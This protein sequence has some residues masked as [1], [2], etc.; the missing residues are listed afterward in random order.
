CAARLPSVQTRALFARAPCDLHSVQN[1]SFHYS[2]Q[3]GAK[4]DRTSYEVQTSKS[5]LC[6]PLRIS[7]ALCVEIAVVRRGRRDTQRAAEENPFCYTSLHA[8]EKSSRRRY[9]RR[10]SADE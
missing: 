1:R 4:N 6:G 2:F 3:L 10:F 5:K 9:Y 8:E 7:A